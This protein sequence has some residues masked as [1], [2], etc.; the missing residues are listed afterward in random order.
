MSRYPWALALAVV[1]VMILLGIHAVGGDF[2]PWCFGAVIV[3]VPWVFFTMD[4]VSTRMRMTV[5][6]L[7]AALATVAFFLSATTYVHVL[8]VLVAVASGADLFGN[9]LR[10]FFRNSA[11]A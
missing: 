6:L 5:F 2:L 3:T 11:H 8:L 7:S 10:S 9:W 1:A 4:T